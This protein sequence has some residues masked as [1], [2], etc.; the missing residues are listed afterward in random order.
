MEI[1]VSIE[2]SGT[3]CMSVDGVEKEAFHD[4]L[5][6]LVYTALTTRRK[7]KKDNQDNGSELC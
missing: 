2:R 7:E 5:Q 4:V 6:E 1:Y 3:I